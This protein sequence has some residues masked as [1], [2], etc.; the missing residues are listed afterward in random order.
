MVHTVFAARAVVSAL[1]T[2]LH[3]QSGQPNPLL[4]QTVTQATTSID[5]ASARLRF[6]Q[7]ILLVS[8]LCRF[9]SELFKDYL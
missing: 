2:R 9:G 1:L 5:H 4:L 3:S 6:S 7:A 8:L